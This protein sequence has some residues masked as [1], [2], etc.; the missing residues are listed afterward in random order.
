[1]NTDKK[2]QHYIPKFYL[3]NFSFNSNKKQIGVFHLNSSFFY[4]TAKLKTQGSKDFFYGHDG[5]IEDSLAEIEGHLATVIHDIISTDECPKKK[6]KEHIELLAFVGLTHLRNPVLIESIKESH[7]AMRQHILELDPKSDANKVVPNMSHEEVVKIALSGIKDV[8]DNISDLDY[9]LLVNKTNTPFLTSDFPV[10]RYNRF[11]EFRKWSHGKTGYAQIGL[12]IF[13]P[14]SP[15]VMIVF[16]DPLV[17][18]VGFKKRAICD[19]T[20]DSDVNKLN[21][22]QVMNCLE[23]IYFNE[24][25]SE[26]YIRSLISVCSRYK[27][28]NQIMSELS[29]LLEKG[30]EVNSLEEKQKNL[31]VMGLTDCETKLEINGI[32][33]HS[34]SKKIKLTDT[35]AQLRPIPKMLSNKSRLH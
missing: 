32:K 25:I 23:T 11:L 19:L 22:L 26:M 3:R 17:Y 14:L 18:K 4:Q 28:A 8:I 20:K 13:I 35:M 24:G 12:Q 7:E 5:E 15:T 9:K 6:S 30:E 21:Q 1:M 31:V 33:M 34:G 2:N 29:Y 27:R 16:Y 10:V